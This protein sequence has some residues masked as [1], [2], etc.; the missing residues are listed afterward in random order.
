[1]PGVLQAALFA[2]LSL[3]IPAAIIAGR[4]RNGSLIVTAGAA[5]AAIALFWLLG[6]VATFLNGDGPYF[7][8][9][10]LTFFAGGMLLLAAWAL[11]LNDAA[12]ARRYWW[13][14][15]LTFGGFVSVTAFL[16]SLSPSNLCLYGQPPEGRLLYSCAGPDRVAL[17]LLIAGYLAGPAVALIY[18]LRAS[19]PRRRVALPGLITSP[20]D[21]GIER[22]NEAGA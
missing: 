20:I 1:V 8:V 7:S 14:A 11:A 5:L 12:Q 17:A 22:E 21:A 3:V 2:T 10:L 9:S 6:G 18:A 15:L 4:R 16:F 19:G 13:V